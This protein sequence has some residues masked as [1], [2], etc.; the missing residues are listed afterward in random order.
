M[1]VTL[2]VLLFAI[3]TAISWSYYGDRSVEFLFGRRGIVPYRIVFTICT[4]VGSVFTLN[5]VWGIADV[6]NGLMAAPNLIALLALSALARREWKAY[7]AKDFD[8]QKR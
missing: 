4:F 3:S 6:A 7:F 2:A 1:I 5:L 8:L